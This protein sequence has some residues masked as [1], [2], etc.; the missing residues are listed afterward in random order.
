MCWHVPYKRVHLHWGQTVAGFASPLG[1]CTGH[2]TGCIWQWKEESRYI[3]WRCVWPQD[4]VR[5]WPL[6]PNAWRWQQAAYSLN[7]SRGSEA[8]QGQVTGVTRATRLKR[9]WWAQVEWSVTDESSGPEATF[10][11]PPLPLHFSENHQPVLKLLPCSELPLVTLRRAGKFGCEST[12]CY[13]SLSTAVCLLSGYASRQMMCV[14]CP[15][16]GGVVGGG[17]R[18]HHIQL[19]PNAYF[20][21][22]FRTFAMVSTRMMKDEMYF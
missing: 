9:R 6:V 5:P 19:S 16:T 17:W 20:H 2:L 22:C 12:L 13:S 18:K 7:I 14:L 10:S 21:G 3:S 11:Q 1:P 4:E 15:Q 8:Y